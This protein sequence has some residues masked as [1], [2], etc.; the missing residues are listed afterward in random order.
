MDEEKKEEN[1]WGRILAGFNWLGKHRKPSIPKIRQPIPEYHA[2]FFSLLTFS[3]MSPILAVSPAVSQ[4]V[5]EDIKAFL[6]PVI[7]AR[8][9]LM[10]YGSSIPTAVRTI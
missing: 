10:T 2:G 9:R 7:D 5:E 6:R 1:V 8:W 4:F 3:W